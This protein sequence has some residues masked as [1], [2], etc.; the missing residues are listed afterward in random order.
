MKEP[1]D[2]NAKLDRAE[3]AN[4]DDEAPANQSFPDMV[5]RTFRLINMEDQVAKKEVKYTDKQGKTRK[6]TLIRAA[7][8]VTDSQGRRINK[9]DATALAK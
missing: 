3:K 9:G 8:V 6:Y 5:W 1:A 2:I 7:F 4:E